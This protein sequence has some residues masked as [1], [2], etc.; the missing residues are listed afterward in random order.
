MFDDMKWCVQQI[1]WWQHGN[2]SSFTTTLIEAFR[3]ADYG[4]KLRLEQGFFTMSQAIIEWENEP[5]ESNLWDRYGI[6]KVQV[7]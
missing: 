3:R 6:E 4:N 5:V 1:Y 7:R 2:S